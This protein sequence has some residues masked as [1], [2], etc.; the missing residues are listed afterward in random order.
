M[1]IITYIVLL[2]LI[3]CSGN[4]GKEEIKI[5]KTTEGYSSSSESIS[6]QEDKTVIS[7][8]VFLPDWSSSYIFNSEV[9]GIL[10]KLETFEER[11]L[12]LQTEI[13]P[14]LD[15]EKAISILTE[16]Y[17]K[18]ITIESKEIVNIHDKKQKDELETWIYKGIKY[19]FY[20]IN[21]EYDG[22]ILASCEIDES[23]DNPLLSPLFKLTKE[24]LIE[25]YGE[26]N[27][28][29]QTDRFF[30]SPVNPNVW[31]E[32]GVFALLKEGKIVTIDFTLLI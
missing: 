27:M 18:P 32:Y 2:M 20:K 28:F 14:S 5:E 12:A 21:K 31:I 10:E 29:D 13:V 9:D 24:Q 17:G 22:C 3:S 6:K 25:L 30:L 1:K 4:N 15:G 8:E 16:K 26:S 7:S 23:I 19:F 11:R